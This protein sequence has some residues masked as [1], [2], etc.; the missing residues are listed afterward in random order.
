MSPSHTIE[1]TVPLWDNPVHLPPPRNRLQPSQVIVE[2]I[3]AQGFIKCTLA[4]NTTGH[5]APPI[6]LPV[7]LKVAHQVNNDWGPTLPIKVRVVTV[8]DAL[9]IILNRTHTRLPP[10]LPHHP[11]PPNNL[12][13]T[14]PAVH[15]PTSLP[16]TTCHPLNFKYRLPLPLQ[17]SR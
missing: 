5:Q 1:P 17:P 15:V 14:L 8:V 4:T 6:L 13:A 11:P 9:G 12:V 3:A 10:P 7:E 16:P 2:V